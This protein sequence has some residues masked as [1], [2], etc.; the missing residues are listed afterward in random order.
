MKRTRLW[1]SCGIEPLEERYAPS[2][3]TVAVIGH[4]LTITGDAEGNAITIDGTVGDATRF[5]VA[6]AADTINRGG[7]EFTTPSGVTGIAIKLLG[8]NDSV[9]LSDAVANISLK[10]SL[11]I[12]GGDGDNTVTA[13][14]LNIGKNFSITNGVGSDTNQFQDFRVGGSLTIK[15]GDGDSDTN[16]AGA[17][18]QTVGG[19]VT[20]TNGT[21]RDAVVLAGLSVKHNVTINNGRGNAVADAG[22]FQIYNQVNFRNVIGGNVTVNYLDG[23]VGISGIS[24]VQVAGN[25]SLNFGSGSG[26]IEF[27]DYNSKQPV[28]I[29]GNV[30]VKGTGALQVAVGTQNGKLGMIVGKAFT[31]TSASA[32]ADNVT[33]NQLVVGGATKISLGDGANAITID[34]AVFNG[35]FTSTTGS[36]ADTVYI[37]TMEDSIFGTTFGGR[38]TI[39]EGAGIDVLARGDI[40]GDIEQY[41]FYFDSVMVRTG[42]DL[43]DATIVGNEVFFYDARLTILP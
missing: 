43:G 29:N 34:D 21:G 36:G 1:E 26:G 13:R 22:F 2:N 42:G 9:T 7:S 28:V 37:E 39:K 32:G 24:D 38:V 4:I 6:A 27:D 16:T 41:I 10:G 33:L 14:N 12:N 25:V 35:A 8:G 18:F 3:L 20:I 11:T 19:N 31:V 30:T 40:G 5:K 23:A 15:N 17:I